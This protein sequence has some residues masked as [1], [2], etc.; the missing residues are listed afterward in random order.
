MSRKITLTTIDILQQAKYRYE[1]AALVQSAIQ[2]KIILTEAEKQGVIIAAADL[3][4][5]A[6][7]LRVKHRLLSA[8]DTLNWLNQQHLSV[9]D[10]EELAYAELLRDRLAGMLFD[11]QIEAYFVDRQLDYQRAII[12]QLML[13]NQ[14][15]AM[16]LFYAW[17]ERETDF[18]ALLHQYGVTTGND[19][20]VHQTLRRRD[21]PPELSAPIFA[22]QPPILLR[23]LRTE[24]G[25][26]LVYVAELIA[27]KLDDRT[28]AK[29]REELF[30]QW[31]QAQQ[32]N[33]EIALPTELNPVT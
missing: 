9:A 18:L 25:F 26:F 15:L 6:D 2:A 33:I 29:I 22:A 7:A 5:A 4:A 1:M 21:L 24:K 27:A 14:E 11:D 20:Q 32:K 17:Q 10:F 28:R 31:L 8:K 13:N 3:Q 12:Y 30:Q 19:Y 23:P 16:E